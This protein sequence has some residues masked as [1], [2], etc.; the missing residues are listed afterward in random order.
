MHKV[1]TSREIMEI[2]IKPSKQEIIFKFCKYLP[3]EIWNKKSCY[4]PCITHL[5]DQATDIAVIFEFYQLY[6]FESIPNPNGT[7][8]DCSGVNSGELLV[9]SCIAFVFYRIISCIWVY[10]ITHSM[11]HTF[12]QFLDLKIYHA[13][14]INFVSDHNDGRP[15]T[16][17]KYIQILEASL[18]AFPQVVIQLY[19]FIQVQLNIN[20]YW[21]VF[22]SLVMSLYVSSKMA[23][24]DRIYFS[25]NWQNV[26]LNKCINIRYLC[27]YIFRFCDVF[28]RIML[29]LLIW[30]GIGGFYC[31]LYILFEIIMLAILSFIT[32]EYVVYAVN[33]DLNFAKDIIFVLF[34]CVYF[35]LVCID[36]NFSNTITT[37]SIPNTLE[38]MVFIVCI[39]SNIYVSCY[40]C[41][42]LSIS[43]KC[44][45]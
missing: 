33:L 28:Q 11:S 31:T 15:N 17:Q 16:A 39:V 7:R 37:M 10:N 2:D 4:F 3:F 41:G 40:M 8:N 35:Q 25:T 30:I 26:C 9:L 42:D 1:G 21:V 6:V 44:N 5:I 13:L 24:E 32:K 14:Y 45:R 38:I 43:F 20:Q 34:V 18:E 36:S 22:A 27:R 29:I 23:S 12:L 19:F